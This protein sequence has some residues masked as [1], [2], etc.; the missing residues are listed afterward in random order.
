MEH[1]KHFHTIM[2][3]RIKKHATG[4]E[5]WLVTWLRGQVVF[6][7]LVIKSDMNFRAIK[8]LNV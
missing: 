7:K 4:L 8:K 1:S 3:V 6:L 5:T 2:Q